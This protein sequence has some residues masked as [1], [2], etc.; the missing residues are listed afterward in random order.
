MRHW[1][2]YGPNDECNEVKKRIKRE[3]RIGQYTSMRHERA[4]H[5]ER[6]TISMLCE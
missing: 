3:I 4:C 5:A 6:G 1:L 2:I